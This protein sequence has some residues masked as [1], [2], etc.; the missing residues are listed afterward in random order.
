MFKAIAV[1]SCFSLVLGKSLSAELP[2]SFDAR[3]QWSSCSSIGTVWDQGNCNSSWALSALSVLADRI[4]I[5]SNQATNVLLSPEDLL[6][7]C[8]DCGDGCEGG[9]PSKAWNYL[10]TKGVTTGFVYGTSY[11]C[12]AYSV[13]PCGHFNRSTQLLK[14]SS[15]S[16]AQLGECSDSC[17]ANNDDTSYPLYYS[18]QEYQ[19]P[20][21][22][23]SIKRE[24][25]TNGPVQAGVTLFED[26]YN[27]YTGLYVADTSDE[28][29]DLPTQYVKVVGWGKTTSDEEYWIILNSW[30]TDWA[31]RGSLQW[32]VN[33]ANSNLENRVYA[34]LPRQS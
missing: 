26:F 33:Q 24:I 3:T 12:K 9:E 14:C 32:L 2:E 8:A 5:A 16:Q 31:R 19:V 29:E 1:I 13:R 28:S 27:H 11:G 22:V 10:S 15:I 17:G 23:E 4:C 6:T 18:Q 34:A 25:L 30:N 7:C 21:D 20:S